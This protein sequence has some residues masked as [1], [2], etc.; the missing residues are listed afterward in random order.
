MI[1]VNQWFGRKLHKPFE[2]MP[3]VIVLRDVWKWEVMGKKAGLQHF[4][5]I[6]KLPIYL[7]A[8]KQLLTKLSFSAGYHFQIKTWTWLASS[9]LHGNMVS[10]SLRVKVSY[11]G[12]K[13][14]VLGKWVFS[15]NNYMGDTFYMLAKGKQVLG[16]C[17]CITKSL[18][19]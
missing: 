10:T 12:F 7:T 1:W 17:I 14:W 5:K 18:F 9:G 2:V 4:C 11:S 6:N 13:G 16:C 15:F 8:H 3:Y 19:S